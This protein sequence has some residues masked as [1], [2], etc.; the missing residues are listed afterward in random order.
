MSSPTKYRFW[1]ENRFVI[2]DYVAGDLDMLITA[3]QSGNFTM[4]QFTGLKDKNGKEIYEGD[5]VR[6][7]YGGNTF[8][9]NWTVRFGQ[10]EADWHTGEQDGTTGAIGFYLDQHGYPEVF[11]YNLIKDL[12]KLEVVGNIYENPEL[13]KTRSY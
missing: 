3:R 13:L 11:V 6:A 9:G 1:Y 4:Q 7:N 10:H 2:I 8:R 12:D 5:I